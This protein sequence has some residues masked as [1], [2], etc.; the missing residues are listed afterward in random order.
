MNTIG[1]L[2]RPLFI[3]SVEKDLC[4]FKVGFWVKTLSL[5][6]KWNDFLKKLLTGGLWLLAPVG[7]KNVW[8]VVGEVFS[9]V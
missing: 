1:E 5:T 3:N 8:V 4:G 6:K 9:C 2:L 7:S